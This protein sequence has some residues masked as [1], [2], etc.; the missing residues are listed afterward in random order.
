MRKI[1]NNLIV[2]FVCANVFGQKQANVWYF[3]DA[4][5]VDFNGSTPVPLTDGQMY[6]NEGC[7][8]I[9]DEDGNL[10][11]YTD[12]DTIWSKNH[13]VMQNG[14]GLKGSTTSTQSSIIVSNPVKDSIYY[15]FTVDGS[16]SGL[17]DGVNYSEV[18]INANGGLGQVTT[19][20]YTHL[21][22]RR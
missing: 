20:S 1:I 6:T 9:S 2:L 3:G 11:F 22:C 18:N 21:R 7:S 4:A 8:T 16:G 19:V 10:L 15:V 12:G 17:F 5:G 13:A 14:T